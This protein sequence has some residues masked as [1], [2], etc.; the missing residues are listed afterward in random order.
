M[1]LLDR[2]A[3]IETE[4]DAI[5]NTKASEQEYGLSKISNACDVTESNN[6]IALS[7]MQNNPSIVGTLANKVESIS[8]SC[9]GY[10]DTNNLLATITEAGAS[11]TAQ[12]NSY[13]VGWFAS[14]GKN[15][16][17]IMIDGVKITR[18]YDATNLTV[19]QSAFSFPIAK[20]QTISTR[21]VGTYSLAVYSTKK[22]ST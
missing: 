6:G 17:H 18:I 4:I 12:E 13:V 16:A 2:I 8:N 15:E 20:G 22:S 9:S 19:V 21:S 11:Y 3:S 1:D 7:A 14:N 5:K 10:I